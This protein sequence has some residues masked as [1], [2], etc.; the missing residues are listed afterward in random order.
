MIFKTFFLPT[1]MTLLSSV[2]F[3]SFSKK[4]NIVDLF[5]VLFAMWKPNW[6]SSRETP[7]LWFNRFKPL[8]PKW[9]RNRTAQMIEPKTVPSHG[10]TVRLI[11]FLKHSSFVQMHTVQFY[12]TIQMHLL[13]KKVNYVAETAV[14]LLVTVSNNIQPQWARP[15]EELG[16]V[17]SICNKV[18][19]ISLKTETQRTNMVTLGI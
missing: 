10:L 17:K 15:Q 6:K 7:G 13:H 11:R 14:Q 5:R 1:H 18:E 8:K 16:K 9:N 3:I 2:R 4:K 12:Q 19:K